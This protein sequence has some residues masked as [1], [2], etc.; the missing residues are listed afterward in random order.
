[1]P[2]FFYFVKKGV[3]L[4]NYN[5]HAEYVFLKDFR[6]IVKFAEVV[7]KYDIEINVES[8]IYKLNAKSMLGLFSL[9]HSVPLKIVTQNEFPESLKRDLKGFML[10]KDVLVS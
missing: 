9:D 5:M 10:K 1:M 7:N 8:S 2:A 3:I 4:V 6:A